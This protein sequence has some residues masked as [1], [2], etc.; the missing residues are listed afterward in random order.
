MKIYT[1]TG[2]RGETGLFGGP[3][4]PKSHARVEAYGT[5]DELCSLLGWAAAQVGDLPVGEDIRE[6]QG[7][8]L[9]IGADLATPPGA[10]ENATTRVPRLGDGAPRRL[11][12][13]IDCLD[14]TLPPL[15][16]FIL[17]GGDEGAAALQVCRTVCRRAERRSVM[18]AGEEDV[19][20]VILTYLNRLSDLLYVMARWINAQRGI[21]EPVW[22]AGGETAS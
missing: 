10:S 15:D 11:E 1:R 7:D 12:A 9:V 20:P 8:L 5:V 14:E 2:D 6:I 3:R 22:E 13:R 17:P 21:D 19:N 4:V 16:R 18:L